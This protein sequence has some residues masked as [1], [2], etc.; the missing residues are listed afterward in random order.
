MIDLGEDDPFPSPIDVDVDVD[1]V[2]HDDDVA[3]IGSVIGIGSISLSL[4]SLWIDLKGVH[5]KIQYN[6]S[7]ESIESINE[8]TRS[9]T[10]MYS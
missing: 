3:V 4:C 7:I 2:G 6:E 9:S 1:V 10:C 5:E 8:S